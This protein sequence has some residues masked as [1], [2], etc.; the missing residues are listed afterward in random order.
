MLHLFNPDISI[1]DQ[2]SIPSPANECAVVVMFTIL[3]LILAPTG[4]SL[5]L[6]PGVG[7]ICL[8]PAKPAHFPRQN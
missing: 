7:L 3:P 2:P 6:R 4:Y 8:Y 5:G 1:Y